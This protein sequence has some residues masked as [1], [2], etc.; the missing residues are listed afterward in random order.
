MDALLD[1]AKRI[2]DTEEAIAFLWE[3]FPTPNA[4]TLKALE[5]SIDAHKHQ[6]RKSGEPYIVHPILVA[7][8]TAKISNDET[9]VQAALLHDV[10]EDTSY[11][12]EEMQET[13]G[14]DVAHLVE[15][16][17]KIVEIR[18]EELAPSGSNE[19]L[20]NSALTFRKML[21]ASIKD[22]RVLVIKL[23]DRVHNMLTLEALNDEKQKRIAEETLVV[24]API[25]HRLGI[26][27]LKNN[28]EDLSFRYIYPHEYKLI[29][30]Y[31]QKNAVNLK[32]KLNGFIQNVKKLMIKDGFDTENF[33]V[34]GRVKHYYSI[35]MKMQRKGVSIEEILDLLA[36][37][38]IVTDPIECY[39]VLGL[40]HLKYT[41]LISR[42]KDYIAVPKEN[43]YKTIHTTL[44]SEEGIVEA[45]IRTHQMHHLAEYGIASH[46]KYKS[47]D[48][49]INLEWLESLHYQH[50]S[51]EEFYELAKSDLFS[52]DITVFSPKG[53]NYTLPKG[54][55]V[56]DFA[57]A[58]HSEV[59]A[60]AKEALVNKEK[61]SLLTI[62]KN[63]DIVKVIKDREN[64]L[65]CS[66]EDAVK[67]SKAQEGIRSACRARIKETDMLSGYNILATLFS[68]KRQDIMMLIKEIDHDDSMNKLPLQL[69]Y[70]KEIIHQVADYLGTKEVRFWELLKKG[71]KKPQIKVLDHFNFY[72]NKPLD[73]VEFDYCCH[74]KV[75]DK[76]VALYKGGKAIIHHKLCKKAYSEIVQGHKM[77]HVSWSTSKLSKYRLT[78]SLQNRKGILADLLTKLSQLNLNI[79]SIELG[80]KNSEQA[81]Y[82]QIEVESSEPKKQIIADK[83]SHS[84]KLIEIISL[85]DAYNK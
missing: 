35:Y 21:I 64:H 32:F 66:W 73:G 12:I 36:I 57:Y 11:T 28:L 39:N 55:V 23:C 10:V 19:R 34:F 43:G 42:F 41:P 31:I 22:V 67:T 56:L 51:I 1:K 45:Q 82:C 4:T 7:A 30:E 71:Y 80:I 61:S 59:G 33:E 2:N 8:I 38:I 3:V 63:G 24:Y 60:K 46:W 20:I 84:F 81:E 68:Q 62:L 47:G 74:P 17:T 37:R 70:Y 53:D 50:E 49:G 40:M 69:D 25:A 18:D 14:D 79:E 76:I 5:L 72:T 27:K 13:F 85:N 48:T 9:M 77:L 44:F 83:I 6:I 75:G 26:S 78:I 52:E 58:I 15:G 16:L 54:S 65:Y 29:D